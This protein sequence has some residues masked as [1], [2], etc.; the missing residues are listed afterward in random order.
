MGESGTDPCM[1]SIAAIGIP[2][3]A[4]CGTEVTMD[5]S[6]FPRDPPMKKLLASMSFRLALVALPLFLLC[7]ACSSSC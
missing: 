1:N 3:L 6:P 4:E 7:A 5:S 2:R